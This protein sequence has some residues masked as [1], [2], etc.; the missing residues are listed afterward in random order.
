MKNR[1]FITAA[2]AFM[3]ITFLIGCQNDNQNAKDKIVAA[4]QNP[5]NTRSNN[6]QY[7]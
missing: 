2:I 5:Q 7:E 3:A 6:E 1:Y 4:N